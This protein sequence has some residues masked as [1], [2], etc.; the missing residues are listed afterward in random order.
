MLFLASLCVSIILFLAL[1]IYLSPF[2][3]EHLR[4]VALKV[5]HTLWGNLSKPELK[6]FL[7]LA[8]MGMVIMIAT[9]GLKTLK[10]SLFIQFVGAEELSTAK[11]VSVGTLIPL[12]FFYNYLTTRF[13]LERIF[14]VVST[15]Y[16]VIF[17]GIGW[18]C[19]FANPGTKE[20]LVCGLSSYWIGWLAYLGTESFSS[21]ITNHYYT[22]I[23][24]TTTTESAKR[25]FGL[26]IVATQLGNLLGPT[27]VM[28]SIDVLGF[29]R[30]LQLFA[31]LIFALPLFVKIYTSAIPATLRS[32]DDSQVSTQ[33]TTP[34]MFDGLSLLARNPYLMGLSF[35]TVFHEF[36]GTMLDLQF[37]IMISKQYTGI[38]YAQYFGSYAQ[39]NA[40]LG[41]VFG[42]FGTS[43]VLR[44]F[45][46]RLCL[47]LYPLMIGS[48]VGYIWF[49]PE[50]S[51]FFAGMVC[52][53]TLGYTL[54]RPIQE[55]MFIPTSRSVKTQVKSIIDGLGKRGGKAF[56]A[57]V[58]RLLTHFPGELFTS[59]IYASLATVAVW[60]GIAVTTGKKYEQLIN[61][62]E[63]IG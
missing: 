17:F 43:F 14:A 37:K 16:A 46:I 53:K 2:L 32:S 55:I 34:S 60:L 47:F 29:G 42:F 15:V 12:I 7:I 45:G 33:K 11:F 21:L 24:S 56:A 62:K 3:Q 52:I 58:L 31:V 27:S 49:H 8:L 23:A 30:L 6:K 61:N 48:I 51:L 22:Y 25:G 20:L 39:A 36:I 13:S 10:D 28:K 40:I 57:S 18:A 19:L 9:W 1:I 44:R 63:I 50:L 59:S 35:I 26:I 54:N 41:I 4:S 38:A 5:E